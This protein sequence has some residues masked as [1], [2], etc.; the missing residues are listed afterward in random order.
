MLHC[1][2]IRFIE[3]LRFSNIDV[4][5]LWEF[6]VALLQ[7][8]IQVYMQIRGHDQINMFQ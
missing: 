2:K 1:N 3:E 5:G 8:G 7:T 6:C 4:D